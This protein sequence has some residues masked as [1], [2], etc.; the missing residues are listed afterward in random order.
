MAAITVVTT[1]F[2]RPDYLRVALT[3][4]LAQT[5]TDWEVL[6]CDNANDSRV[7]ELLAELDDK[8]LV[9]VPRETN[10]GLMHNALE[11]FKAAQGEFIVKLDDD[12]A[13]HPDFLAR[14]FAALRDHPEAV[15]AFTDVAYMDSEGKALSNHQAFQDGLREYRAFGAGLIR[16]FLD[17][18]LTGLALNA[19]LLRRDA[20]DWGNLIEE[21]STSYDL[22]ILLEACGDYTAAYYIPER[23]VEYRVHPGGDTAR[24]LIVLQEGALAAVEHAL[25]SPKGYDRATLTRMVRTLSV[26]LAREYLREGRTGDA[27]QVVRPALRSGI[28]VEVARLTALSLV[29]G[30]VASRI[31]EARGRRWA[32]QAGLN[33]QDELAG[34]SS[35]PVTDA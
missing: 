18:V 17:V 4:L 11:G 19:A 34:R 25:A 22:H 20:V 9:Y 28:D 5:F 6:V 27:L 7:S 2:N 35:T 12:D 13:F 10:L 29:P 30:K 31:V 24:R 8:R 21:A 26:G 23:L 15:L 33:P 1:T 16:P 3:S 32:E 14:T